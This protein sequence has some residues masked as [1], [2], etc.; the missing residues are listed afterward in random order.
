ML[1][2]SPASQTYTAVHNPPAGNAPNGNTRIAEN[3][4]LIENAYDVDHVRKDK[5]PDSLPA[6]SHAKTRRLQFSCSA[7]TAAIGFSALAGTVV[8]SGLLFNGIAQVK[9]FG[10]DCNET[11]FEKIGSWIMSL[12]GQNRKNNWNDDLLKSVG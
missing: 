4:I 6:A 8:V 9:S 10:S 11:V 7:R 2:V 12:F 3:L 1:H 5:V